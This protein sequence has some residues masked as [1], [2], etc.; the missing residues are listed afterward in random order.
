MVHENC[1]DMYEGYMSV[2][3]TVFVQI[4]AA[5]FHTAKACRDGADQSHKEIQCS[6]KAS[7]RP[8]EEYKGLKGTI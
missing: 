2:V 6:L 3:K 8:E 7:L 5:R 4:V 1:A